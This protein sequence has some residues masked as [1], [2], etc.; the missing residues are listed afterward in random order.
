MAEG[1]SPPQG[2]RQTRGQTVLAGIRG[3]RVSVRFRPVPPVPHSIRAIGDG[4]LRQR[5]TEAWRVATRLEAVC[6]FVGYFQFLY[7]H[8]R[9]SLDD[10]SQRALTTESQVSKAIANGSGSLPWAG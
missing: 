4:L 1:E 10:K 3:A 9:A 7:A 5:A 8:L 6:R 2:D